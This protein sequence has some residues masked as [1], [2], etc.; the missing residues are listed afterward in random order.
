M[1]AISI[2]FLTE[3]WLYKF[4]A[5]NEMT[6]KTGQIFIKLSYSYVSAFI[7]YFLVVHL[8]REKKKVN[9]Y[10]IISIKIGEISRFLSYVLFAIEQTTGDKLQDTDFDKA[11]L[12]K[13]LRKIESHNPVTSVEPINIVYKDWYDFIQYNGE[14]IK[15]LTG[16]I[17]LFNE[18]LDNELIELVGQIDKIVSWGFTRNQGKPGNEDLSLYAEGLTQLNNTFRMTNRKFSEKY[19]RYHY[20]VTHAM[21]KRGEYKP[22]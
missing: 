16:E 21:E 5:Y 10:R 12:I 1:I 9:S 20:E 15:R 18:T 3:L 4:P 2:V 13:I 7:F 19:G 22:L 11:S 17:F 8:P 14:E 6:Y